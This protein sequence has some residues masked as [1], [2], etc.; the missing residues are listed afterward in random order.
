MVFRA[1]VATGYFSGGCLENDVANHALAVLWSGE[2]RKLVYGRGSPWFDIRLACGGTLEILLERIDPQDTAVGALQKLT[3]SRNSAW[4]VSD[5][6]SRQV[7][8][9]ASGLSASDQYQQHY[10]PVWRFVV[11]GGD[12]TALAI[13]S[14]SSSVGFETIVIRPDGPS[15]QPPLPK[16]RYVRENVRVAI[17]RLAPDPWTAV[18]TATHDDEIDDAALIAALHTD[19]AYVGVLGSASKIAPR[20]GRLSAAGLQGQQIALLHAPIGAL[21]CGKAPWEIAVSVIAEV[22]Q[23]RTDRTTPW[24]NATGRRLMATA[25]FS[26][27]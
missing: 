1:T 15:S 5:G 23:A 24:M 8:D 13:A 10:E 7:T 6:R 11:V 12:P 2:P 3:K 19:A 20:R 14:L 18:V 27:K 4:W 22:M 16:V 17:E 25:G 9:H 26:V 21:R